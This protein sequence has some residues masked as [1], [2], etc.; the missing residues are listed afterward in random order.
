MYCRRSP[1]ETLQSGIENGLCPVAERLAVAI[2]EKGVNPGRLVLAAIDEVGN[3][4]S[5]GLRPQLICVSV[6]PI[7]ARLGDFGR[8]TMRE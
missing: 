6:E 8:D 1:L 7:R 4:F 3:K 5:F 2:E